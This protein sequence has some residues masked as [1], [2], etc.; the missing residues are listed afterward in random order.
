MSAPD[1]YRNLEPVDDFHK[2]ARG[3]LYVPV[4]ESWVIAMTD[5]VSS[6]KAVAAGRYRDV[7]RAGGIAIM[8]LSNLFGDLDLPFVFGGDGVTF[9][10]PADFCP[11]AKDVLADTRDMVKEVFNLDLRV[12]FIP[13]KDL[14]EKGFRLD[15]AK[16][17]MSRLYNQAMFFGNG[18]EEAEKL[19]KDPGSPYLLPLDHP[20]VERANFSGFNCRWKDIKS[21]RGETLSL[22]IKPLRD[23]VTENFLAQMQNIVGDEAALHP[24]SEA[25]MIMGGAGEIKIEAR[26]TSGKGIGFLLHFLKTTLML[27][28]GNFLIRRN[29]RRRVEINSYDLVDLRKNMM[30]ATDYRKYDGALKMVIACTTEERSALQNFLDREEK[31]GALLYGM[32]ISDRALLT[33]LINEGTTREV[34]FVDAADGGYALAAKMLKEKTAPP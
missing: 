16:F 22:I 20:I 15:V 5:V 7:N 13:V 29:M 24:L 6:T 21:H 8:A 34:H 14:K 2:I 18:M 4:P 10:L 30:G 33:C 17:H 23:G 9:L 26:V 19:A 31:Q 1:F 25:K 11:S 3:N 32:H 28:A 12:A 27:A